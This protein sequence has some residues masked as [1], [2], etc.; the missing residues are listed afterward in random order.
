[1]VYWAG[2]DVDWKLFAAVGIG[3]TLLAVQLLVRPDL[4]HGTQW[5]N[6]WWILV[7]YA[8]LAVISW[9][10]IYSSDDAPHGQQFNISF[11]WGFLVLL[12]L[13]A[14][15]YELARRSQ[16]SPSQAQQQIA[17]ASRAE[18]TTASDMGK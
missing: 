16:L 8:G 14:I 6:G 4:R 13:T 2:W 10:G 9:Q 17:G 12:G 3:L 1:M 5:R 11:G 7:W 18:P 15:V